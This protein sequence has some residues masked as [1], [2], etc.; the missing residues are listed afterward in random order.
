MKCKVFRFVQIFVSS[1]PFLCN[2]ILVC[3][4]LYLPNTMCSLFTVV[5]FGFWPCFVVANLVPVVY[6]NKYRPF[7]SV[8][9]T[10]ATFMGMILGLFYFELMDPLVGWYGAVMILTG[11][12]MNLLPVAFA[13][14]SPI[15]RVLLKDKG[16]DPEQGKETTGNQRVQ[17]SKEYNKEAEQQSKGSSGNET[18]QECK[19]NCINKTDQS[20]K[21]NNRTEDKEKKRKETDLENQSHQESPLATDKGTINICGRKVG[22]LTSCNPLRMGK[23]LAITLSPGAKRGLQAFNEYIV[24]MPY[25]TIHLSFQLL[26]GSFA[27]YH[28]LGTSL[29]LLQSGD[30][31]EAAFFVTTC[32]IAFM[33]G[34]II[35]QSLFLKMAHSLRCPN[36]A[37]VRVHILSLFIF[38]V[39]GLLYLMPAICG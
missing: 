14:Q 32:M 34:Y 22:L 7:A 29:L 4:R 38:T 30:L 10:T 3:K 35:P 28:F 18:D 15:K 17:E 16:T 26:T 27:T 13:M 33:C 9:N 12:T 19:K 11:V 21:V 8:C 36:A 5:G 39:Y 1:R 6:F 24:C 31:F 23:E 25:L 20:D 37:A 2:K